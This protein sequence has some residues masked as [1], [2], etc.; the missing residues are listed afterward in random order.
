MRLFV[1]NDFNQEILFQLDS[2]FCLHYNNCGHDSEI[3][4]SCCHEMRQNGEFKSLDKK[5]KA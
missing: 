3:N 1:A 5:Q 2:I 4:A